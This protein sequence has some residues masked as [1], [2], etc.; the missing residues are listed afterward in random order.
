MGVFS[1]I[2]AASPFGPLQAHMSTVMECV[3]KV[4]ELFEAVKK[5]EQEKIQPLAKEISRLEHSAD[6][7]KNDIRNSLR[8]GLFMP[9]DRNDILEMLG[10]QDSLADTCEDIGMLLTYKECKIPKFMDKHFWAFLDKN[11]ET[12][13]KASK[14]MQEMDE[15]IQSSFGGKEAERVMQLVEQ[16]A[17][18]EHEADLVQ[19]KLLQSLFANEHE[20][21]HGEFILWM[22]ILR[23]LAR[24]SNSAEKL[25]NR[26]RMILEIK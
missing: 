24:L 23:T 2:F 15:L 12:I 4:P 20:F 5:G 11:L 7:I 1:K 8:Q 10:I 3:V 13:D 22:G 9:V 6:L 17:Y 25:A 14:V 18:A 21:T 19:Q 26:V 16:V